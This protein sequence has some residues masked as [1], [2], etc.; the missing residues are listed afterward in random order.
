M[1]NLARRLRAIHEMPSKYRGKRPVVS[2]HLLQKGSISL[3]DISPPSLSRKRLGNRNIQDENRTSL[4]ET[5]V[6]ARDP[7]DTQASRFT[8]GQVGWSVSVTD[9]KIVLFQSPCDHVHVFP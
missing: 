5:R 1:V 4:R 2:S 8:V 9:D 3:V 7:L 6:K